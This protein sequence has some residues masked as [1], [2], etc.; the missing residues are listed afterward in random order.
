[1]S[2]ER[3]PDLR[4]V[5]GHPVLDLVNTVTP[6]RRG[7]REHLTSPTAL[8]A[9][10]QR[11]G[12]VGA[13]EVRAIGAAWR[14]RS[15]SAGQ[16]LHATLDVRESVYGIV[17]ARLADPTPKPGA[18]AAA[19][20]HLTLRWAA[21]TARST[22]VAAAHQPADVVVGTDP[23]FVVPDRLAFAAVELLRSVDPGHVKECPVSEGGCG[24]LF[25][26][27]SRNGSRRWC[28]MADCGAQAKARKLTA[29]RRAARASTVRG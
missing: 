11:V 22:L 14:A 1:M 4:I 26:D 13:G 24:W 27:Q 29:R 21:A 19:L 25:L 7:G 16:A 20:E 5:G 3:K 15:G 18:T 12:L 28:A 9:W 2:V 8:L 23:A 6:R 10:S 17:A